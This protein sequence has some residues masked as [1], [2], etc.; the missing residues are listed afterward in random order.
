MLAAV[1]AAFFLAGL[2]AF[3]FAWRKARGVPHADTD[4]EVLALVSEH[5]P[6]LIAYIGPDL[7][8][9]WCNRAYAEWFGSTPAELRGRFV[10]DVLGEEA[11]ARVKPHAESAF[12]G[13]ATSY[14]NEVRARD[15]TTRWIEVASIPQNDARGRLVG[16]MV[17]GHDV[18][19]RQ[20]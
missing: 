16:T 15:G 11:W 19:R 5:V 9:R 6:S 18:T 2:A 14:V 1:A 20:E 17:V 3:A 13:Q 8:Y 12:R 7:R 10:P 4:S